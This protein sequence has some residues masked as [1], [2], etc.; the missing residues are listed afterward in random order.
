MPDFSNIPTGLKI[1]TQIPL[2]VKGYALNEATLAYLGVGDN[3]AFTYHE[4][5]RVVCIEERKVYEWREV[6][7][8]EENTGLIAVDFTYPNSHI[9]YGIDYSN[10]TFNFFKTK[11]DFEI[12]NVGTGAK[13]YKDSTIVG[14]NTQFNLRRLKS[15]NDT[16]IISELTDELDIKI[17]LVSNNNSLLISQTGTELN[18][19]INPSWIIQFLSDNPS[20]IC[21]IANNCS[22]E[23]S[24]LGNFGYSLTGT[25]CG[26][27][28]NVLMYRDA[29]DDFFELATILSIDPLF[30]EMAPA[31][32]YSECRADNSVTINRY[33]DGT[34]FVGG[35][36]ICA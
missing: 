14:N 28:N 3:L 16:L 9:V 19:Q 18:L 27:T 26:L 34:A 31:G 32:H 1:T 29:V 2:D 13:V 22:R 10:R 4:G 20:V 25:A 35:P 6:E 36:D 7:A 17:D 24:K 11:N 30:S 12:V 15:S 5:L 33:W 23:P 8:G 21:Q